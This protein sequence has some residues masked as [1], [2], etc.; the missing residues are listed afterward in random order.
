MP[1]P[2]LERWLYSSLEAVVGDIG[3]SSVYCGAETP[4]FRPGEEHRLD[5]SRVVSSPQNLDK[6]E[7]RR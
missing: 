2:Y 3:V 6:Q 4:A 1:C 5:S 7:F